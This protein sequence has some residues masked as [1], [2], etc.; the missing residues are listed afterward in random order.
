MTKA[1]ESLRIV[2]FDNGEKLTIRDV[3]EFDNTGNWLRV[4]GNSGQIFLLNPAKIL[5]HRIWAENFVNDSR[6]GH[7]KR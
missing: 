3:T 4:K 6:K 1:K 2:G 5:F 7:K